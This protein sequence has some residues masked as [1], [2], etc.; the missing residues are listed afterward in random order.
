M[1]GYAS[2]TSTHELPSRQVLR[3]PFSRDTPRPELWVDETIQDLNELTLEQP[4]LVF[5]ASLSHQD[6]EFYEYHFTELFVSVQTLSGKVFGGGEHQHFCRKR[7]PWSPEYPDEFYEHVKAVAHPDPNSQQ[8]ES[9]VRDN[10]ERIMLINGIVWK[11]LHA[12]VLSSLMFGAG[13]DHEKALST[14]DDALM[15]VEGIPIPRHIF[16]IRN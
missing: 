13:E 4:D 14:H 11:V 10:G 8:W 12:N 6:D 9:L 1:T 7:S 3:Y 5:P 2:K 15:D 16:L